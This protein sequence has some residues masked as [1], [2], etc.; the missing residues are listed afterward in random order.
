MWH[1]SYFWS[2]VYD[3]LLRHIDTMNLYKF[4]TI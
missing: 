4:I 3:V 2:A 1:L